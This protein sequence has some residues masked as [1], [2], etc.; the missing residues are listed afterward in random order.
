MPNIKV[1]E[2]TYEELIRAKATLE[3]GDGKI[4]TLDETIA[5]MLEE[6]PKA[7]IIFEEIEE[8]KID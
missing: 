8:K 1:S 3:I 5:K 4:Y 6:F 2:K 7:K